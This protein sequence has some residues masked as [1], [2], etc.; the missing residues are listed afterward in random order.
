MNR[1]VNLEE[2]CEG[3]R[4]PHKVVRRLIREHK[5]VGFHNDNLTN[6]KNWRF[7]DPS[8][9][10]KK[11]LHA[12]ESILSRRY[13]IDLMQFPIVSSAELAQISGLSPSTI[14]NFV[15]DGTLKPWK[16][17]RYSIYTPEQVREFLLR[18]ERKEPRDRRARCETLLRWCLA[19]LE[20][21]PVAS[22]TEKE[23]QRDDKLE[24][25]LR[26]IMRQKE[27]ARSTNLA[28]FWRRWDLAGSAAKLIRK[29]AAGSKQVPGPPSV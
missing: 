6:A 24:G 1:W 3:L 19:Q 25:A 8:E 9:E 26:K 29:Q 17:G 15:N 4:L 5:I 22:L 11:A 16:M 20:A 12:Q 7:L 2:L 14:R 27:P 21:N 28:E 10:Y 18:R 13:R 23:V